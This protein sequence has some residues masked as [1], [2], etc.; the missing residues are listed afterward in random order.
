MTPTLI[1]FLK[2]PVPGRVKTRLARDVGPVAAAGWYR[3]QASR[4]LRALGR[5]PRW[6][7]VLALSPDGAVLS[8]RAWSQGFAR[9]GQ[10]RGSLGARM[11]RSLAAG[12]P[13]PVVLI[14][15]DVPGVGCAEIAAAFQAL[16]GADAVI[17]PS[18]DGGFWL[19]GLA[20]G[21]RLPGR[22]LAG[23]AAGQ[24]VVGRLEPV[25]WSSPHAR[26][27]TLARLHPLRVAFA[28][29]RRDVDDLSDIEALGLP[30][31]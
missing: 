22:R 25:R 9:M 28:P 5:D 4:L 13:G 20:A 27:D 14:G 30:S 8:S 24:G 11:A 31:P 3:H 15:S 29:E 21:R 12:G 23:P 19:I 10:G 18:P 17:G 16:R 1:I 6:R 26:A 7:V 2:E